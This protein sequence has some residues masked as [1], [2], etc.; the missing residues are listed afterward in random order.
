MTANRVT[1]RLAPPTA[2]IP[3]TA[4]KAHHYSAHG[5]IWRNA[6]RALPSDEMQRM[7]EDALARF[8]RGALEALAAP[9]GASLLAWLLEAGFDLRNASAVAVRRPRPPVEQRRD[10]QQPPDAAEPAPVLRQ[11]LRPDRFDAR[12]AP[13]DPL[14]SRVCAPLISTSAR[15]RRHQRSRSIIERVRRS[16][17]PQATLAA[18]IRAAHNGSEPEIKPQ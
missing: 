17:G 3:E 7:V 2:E 8:G 15:G 5:G 12:R 18:P 9:A 10:R 11:R 13:A 4:A 1:A 6:Q 16:K 14:G